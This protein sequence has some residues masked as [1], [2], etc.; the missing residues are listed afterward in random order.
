MGLYPNG[1]SPHLDHKAIQAE[2]IVPL[3]M[4]FTAHIQVIDRHMS[5]P[6]SYD[7]VTDIRTGSAGD[8]IV[9]DSGPNG[10]FCQSIR[11]PT[12]VSFGDQAIGSQGLQFQCLLDPDINTQSG[13]IIKVLDGGNDPS[14][15]AWE[16]M[17]F[18]SV[19]SSL[20][21]GRVYEC[22]ALLS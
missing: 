7:P 6:G 11:L 21:W 2:M 4:M 19:N 3:Q 12:L 14:L 8:E 22:R 1:L 10:A 20:A 16:Y 13:L 15:T 17:L 18:D 9:F 5:T